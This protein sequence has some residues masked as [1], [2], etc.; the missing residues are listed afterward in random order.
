M[1]PPANY[2]VSDIK[3]DNILVTIE[4]KAVLAD[5]VRLQRKNPQVCHTRPEDGRITYLSQDDFGPLQGSSLLP[6][7]AD[8]TS[9]SLACPGG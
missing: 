7:L 9:P 1:V 3:D 8:F 5:F 2:D 6:K 4:N